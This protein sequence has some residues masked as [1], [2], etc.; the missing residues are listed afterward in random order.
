M[1]TVVHGRLG[2]LLVALFGVGEHPE[3]VDVG[4]WKWTPRLVA[5]HHIAT[6]RHADNWNRTVCIYPVSRTQV[7]VE[8]PDGSTSKF[9]DEQAAIDAAVEW[10]SNA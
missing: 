7:V 9:V 4:R 10:M 5:P 1:P 3:Q 2:A 8:L 6:W